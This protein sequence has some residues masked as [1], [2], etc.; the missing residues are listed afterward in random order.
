MLSGIPARQ[1]ESIAEHM[2][3][4]AILAL[5]IAPYSDATLDQDDHAHIQ[6]LDVSKC[7]KMALI[8]DLAESIVGDIPP[9]ANVPKSQ[10]HAMELEA[11]QKLN[12]LLPNQ[13]VYDL[14][15]E[16]EAQMTR[17]AIMVKD[18]DRFE[19][20]LQAYEYEMGKS[21]IKDMR[22][23]TTH[24]MFH[25]SC[26]SWDEQTVNDIVESSCSRSLSLCDA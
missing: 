2:Y 3:R 8:H 17:E 14:W 18:L 19:M 16:Y 25:V 4:M 1:A 13:Q 21:L 12:D 24:F 15:T 22:L 6:S 5:A 26:F 9:S 20:L 11:M 23:G 10:K 7:V